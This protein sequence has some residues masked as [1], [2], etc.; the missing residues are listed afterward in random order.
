[1]V[2]STGNG[3][4]EML[5]TP[6]VFLRLG[7]NSALRVISSNLADTEVA[8]D[9]GQAS[10]EADYFSSDN[11]LIVNQGMASTTILKRGFYVLNVNANQPL[12]QVLDGKAR[13]SLNGKHE[14]VG[15]GEGVI[16]ATS[17]KLKVRGY[18]QKATQDEALVRWSRLRSEYEAEA[19]YE[20]AQTFAGNYGPGYGY[21][22]G[23]GYGYGPS[24]YGPG[25]YWDAGFGFWSFLP[26]DGF[27]Y[28]PFGWG[29]YSPAFLYGYPGFYGRPGYGY[30][31]GG[32]R[33][34]AIGGGGFRGGGFGGGG[35]ARGGGGGRR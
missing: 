11:R 23:P 29:F 27:L 30:V 4:V 13:V 33:G 2:L 18:N 34:A 17:G 24:W 5:L 14:D 1:M 21:A 32:F 9:K 10:V 8:L 26:G 35:F 12:V 16:V 22:S 28:S 19:N 15:K 31:G 6:G 25:W 3:K 7:E 20:T